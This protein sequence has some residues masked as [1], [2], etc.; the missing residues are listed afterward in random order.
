MYTIWRKL[1]LIED[2]LLG[3]ARE[4]VNYL[5]TNYYGPAQQIRCML[6]ERV[7]SLEKNPLPDITD[8]S[9]PFRILPE[10]DSPFDSVCDYVG[11]I[12]YSYDGKNE[13]TL[14]EH[15]CK[16]GDILIKDKNNIP[17]SSLTSKF[18]FYKQQV[19]NSPYDLLFKWYLKKTLDK[20]LVGL[21]ITYEEDKWTFD[22][23]IFGPEPK[24]SLFS[25]DQCFIQVL[26]SGRANSVVER[27]SKSF[28][29]GITFH[30]CYR[31][32]IY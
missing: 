1:T 13:F 11:F 30:E 5:R 22:A 16:R 14:N 18:S 19:P 10:S 26:H 32:H 25:P 28:F 6:R 24:S 9:L 31:I 7:Q 23:I 12:F 15:Q 21:G 4:V 17:S 20:R 29:K 8:N 3:D 27:A 2:L